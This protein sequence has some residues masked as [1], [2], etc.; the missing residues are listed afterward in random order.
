MHRVFNESKPV[1][2]LEG[3]TKAFGKANALEDV[4]LAIQPGKLTALL[5]PNGA[6]KTTAIRTLLGL[7]RPDVGT[8]RLFGQQPKGPEDRMRTGVMLQTAGL[9]NTLRVVELVDLFRS[10]YA[11]PLSTDDVV[12]VASLQG[13]EKQ[14]YGTLSGGQK[15]RLHFAL[16]LCGNPDL[17]FLD[18]PT[19]GLDVESRR[20]FWE[21]IRELTASGRSIVLTTHYLEEADALADHIVVLQEG[22]VR[23]EGTPSQLKNQVAA[24]RVRCLT[25]LPAHEV[26]ELDGVQHVVYDR[27]TLEIFT[28]D[29]ENV[30]RQLLARDERLSDLEVLPT[31][32]EDAFLALTASPEK[33]VA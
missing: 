31:G 8:A 3:V 6:G 2:E 25:S 19:V 11:E 32:I 27:A 4:S 7:L 5:G 13:I 16:A 21:R 15:Q 23:A 20:L 30:V 28:S 10:Y 18:E 12:E 9:P 1:A 17:L 33:E 26:S 29:A 22:R 24:R 14:S